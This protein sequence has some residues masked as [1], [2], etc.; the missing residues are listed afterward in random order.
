MNNTNLVDTII[1]NAKSNPDK[2]ILKDKWQIW[3]WK[4]LLSRSFE[5]SQL[6]EKNFHRKHTSAVPILVGR[7][8]ESIAAILGTILT[9][10]TFAP[11]SHNQ[12]SSRIRTIM[13]SLDLDNIISGLHTSENKPQKIQILELPKNNK[14]ESY[15][16]T[17]KK[18]IALYLLFTSGST[19]KPKGV[20]CSTENILNTL[21]WSKHYLNWKPFDVIGCA[22]QFSFDIS[23]FD[24]F[25]MLYY[26][27]PLAILDN[28]SNPEYTLKQISNFKIT[29]LFSVPAFFSQFTSKKFIKNISDSKLR[30]I[31]S[32]GDFFPPKHTHFWLKNFSKISIY[33]VWGPTE[34]SIVNTMH[35]ITKRDFVKIQNGDYTP[36]GKSHPL[37]E[38]ILI[39]TKNEKIS[40]HNEIGELVIL[41]KSVSMKYFNDPVET[42]KRYFS[43]NNKPA[44]RT[45]DL[46]YQDNNNNF[47]IVGRNDNLVKIRG[48]RIDLNEIEKTL[49]QFPNIYA[50]SVFVN[51]SCINQNELWAAVEL[52]NKD[53][54]LNIFEIKK[55]LRKLLPN[56]MVPK[57]LFTM[58]KIP[59][60]PNGKL[61]K[62]KVLKYV[63]QN[64]I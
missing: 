1:Q 6:I 19:G 54:K 57:R 41:G 14:L 39:N 45:G 52:E 4:T 31:I 58:P 30:R 17:S 40:K 29:S 56:Y 13:N 63:N 36:I 51:K 50:N 15:H 24:L 33:N 28:T 8:S 64:F 62:K 53:S 49:S 59:L 11:I 22:T 46:G 55:K 3:N 32:G 5:Y 35:K 18:N 25:T 27:I 12:P 26:N 44:F 38:L 7:S 34:T 42:K 43:I 37:M 2:I 9:G 47:Y 48:Y 16:H 10:F 60:T 23:L 20:L 21:I 61:D